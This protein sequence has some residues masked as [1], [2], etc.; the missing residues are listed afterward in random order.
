M[1][2]ELLFDEFVIG[3]NKFPNQL[4]QDLAINVGVLSEEFAS[5]AERFAWY[6]TAYD[7]ASA[8]EANLKEHV[9]RLYAIVDAETRTSAEMA[10]VKMTEKKV[11]NTVITDERYQ[12]AVNEYLEARRNASL[13][14]SA[15]DAMSHRRDMLIQM[16]AT[17]RAEGASDISLREQQY[18][19]EHKK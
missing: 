17:Y 10:G 8:H 16:G 1:D 9:S 5:H 14:K 12:V 11:E 15:R 2:K 3:D 18:L 19:R 13:L 6:A 7:I 4:A